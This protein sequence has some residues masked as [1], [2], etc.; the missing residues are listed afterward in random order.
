MKRILVISD[1]FE[2]VKFIKQM[3]TTSIKDKFLIDYCYS[4]V[5][6]YPSSLQRLDMEPIDV[7]KEDTISNI[8][9]C[10][11]LV[12]SAHCKQIFPRSLVEN[13]RCI[14]VHPGLNPYN[15]GWYPQV[16]SIINKLPAGCTI[17]EMNE[18]IDD[19]N[20]IY[21]KE[22]FIEESDTSLAVY[23]K[24]QHA[25]KELLEENFSNIVFNNYQSFPASNSGNYN[26]VSDFNELCRLNRNSEGTLREHI[27]LLRALTHGEHKNAYYL[28]DSGKKVYVQIILSKDELE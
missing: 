25:E 26:G 20:I 3:E 22:V 11:D 1:N 7:K 6:K 13:V 15:R 16:F 4:V 27:D 14:N 19:G 28:D 2:L 12:I 5:N 8:I 21:Q 9:K 10:Y 23:N 18:N 24:V 17:H